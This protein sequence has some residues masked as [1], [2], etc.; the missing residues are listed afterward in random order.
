[1]AF[2]EAIFSQYGPKYL[3]N[4]V[5][6]GNANHR[7][8][9]AASLVK[10]VSILERDRQQKRQ[11]P[12]ALAPPWWESFH[13][14]LDHI[15]TDKDRSI[16][17]AIYKYKFPDHYNQNPP[18]YVIA[19]RGTILKRKSMSQDLKLDLL[20]ILNGLRNSSRFRIGL[21]AVQN[22]VDI[23]NRVCDIWLAGHS[24]GAAIALL[25]GKDMV[26]LGTRLETYLFNPPFSSLPLEKIKINWLKHGLRRARS[27]AIA[28]LAN[29]MSTSDNDGTFAKLYDWTPYL[30]VNPSDPI[31]S[32]YIGY[33]EYMKKMV[34]SGA[35]EIARI[36]AQ[37]SLRSLFATAIG[38]ESEPSQYLP[39][40]CVVTNLS[41]LASARLLS[42]RDQSL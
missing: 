23:N 8:C 20:V 5:D 41:T 11:G 38:K 2:D 27:E 29:T 36:E 4:N 34:E 35:D 15:L 42:K 19:F 18:K 13:F 3:T 40:A 26:K 31:C 25:I 39:S 17:G 12:N 24:L 7:R 9:I 37:N 30:F 1:M 14:I 10:G 21:Q 16:S 33:F 6:W 32:E 28:L 22:I